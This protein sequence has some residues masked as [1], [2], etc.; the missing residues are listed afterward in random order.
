MICAKE[1]DRVYVNKV[2][3]D[4]V[5]P[6]HAQRIKAH[7]RSLK[8]LSVEFGMEGILFEK[9]ELD[10]QLSLEL[11]IKFFYRVAKRVAKNERVHLSDGFKKSFSMVNMVWFF[12][13]RLEDSLHKLGTVF[14][15]WI[16]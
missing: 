7:E 5:V 9:T 16:F 8:C 1:N 14:T 12:V 10:I 11:W 3:Y 6:P 4:A 13:G 15:L 2:E